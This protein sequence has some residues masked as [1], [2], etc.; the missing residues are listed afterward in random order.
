MLDLGWIWGRLA[1]KTKVLGV[2]SKFAVKVEATKWAL[3][4]KKKISAGNI[5]SRLVFYQSQ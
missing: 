5:W 3:Q 4:L 1:H 2:V